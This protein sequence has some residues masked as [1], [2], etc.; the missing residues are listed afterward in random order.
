MSE[1]GQAIPDHDRSPIPTGTEAVV[2][3]E[4][5]GGMANVRIFGR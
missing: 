1:A 2:M 3:V 4:Y 5:T